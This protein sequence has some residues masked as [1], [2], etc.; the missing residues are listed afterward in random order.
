MNLNKFKKHIEFILKKAARVSFGDNLVIWCSKEQSDFAEQ[1]LDFALNSGVGNAE[2]FH[3]DG[4]SVS[5]I[6][7]NKIYHWKQNQYKLLWLYS[8]TCTLFPPITWTTVNVATESWAKRVFPAIENKNTAVDKLWEAIFTACRTDIDDPVEEWDK[9][10]KKL[11]DKADKLNDFNFNQLHIKNKSGTDLKMKL[12]KN[13]QWITC[14]ITNHLGET[15]ITNLPTEEVFT[16]PDT[17]SLNGVVYASKPIFYNNEL[18]ENFR[19]YFKNGKIIDFYAEKNMHLLEQLINSCNNS[20]H[21][22][23]VAIVPHSCPVSQLG[24]FWYDTSFDENAGCHLAFGHS[25]PQTIKNYIQYNNEELSDIGFNHCEIHED[26]VIGTEDME[27]TGITENSEEITI[28]LN[29]EW[30]I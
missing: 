15:V 12:V 10:I 16:S 23:E 1:I 8:D 27:I 19:L 11:T 28:F 18:I 13:H 21:I 2:I 7:L 29:G 14:T 22:G 17:N 20:D 25:Y 6:P 30:N 9:H 3:T 4:L 5:D 26:F 24:I